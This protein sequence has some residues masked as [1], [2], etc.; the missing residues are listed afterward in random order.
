MRVIHFWFTVIVLATSNW[1][2]VA[3]VLD[4]ENPSKSLAS[5]SV[6]VLQSSIY[7]FE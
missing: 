3:M 2:A 7:R 4:V 1:P 5:A 6:T